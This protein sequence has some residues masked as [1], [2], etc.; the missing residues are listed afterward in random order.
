M[1]SYN[2]IAFPL[3]LIPF[4]FYKCYHLSL[5]H[6]EAFKHMLQPTTLLVQTSFPFQMN[7]LMVIWKKYA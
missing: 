5:G 1:I 3:K 4:H 6:S 2:E 7:I